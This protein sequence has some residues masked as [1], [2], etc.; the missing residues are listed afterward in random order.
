MWFPS[1]F[2]HQTAASVSRRSKRS[3]RPA[4]CGRHATRPLL[5]ERLEHRWCPSYSLV[6]SRTATSTSVEPSTTTSAI[7]A[8]TA[9]GRLRTARCYPVPTRVPGTAAARLCKG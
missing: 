6:T 7:V 4:P 5:V 2:Q 8:T 9:R 1:C 3:G